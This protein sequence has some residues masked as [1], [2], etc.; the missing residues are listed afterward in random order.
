MD[1]KPNAWCRLLAVLPMVVLLFFTSVAG[2]QESVAGQDEKNSKDIHNLRPK[3]PT[4]ELVKQSE[5]AIERGLQFL[6]KT[7]NKDGS[8]GSHDPDIPDLAD[9]GFNLKNRG[10]QDGVRA[11]C[12]SI[13]AEAFL[14]QEKLTQPQQ[15]AFEKAVADLL[16]VKKFTPHLRAGSGENF[17]TWG[18]GYKLGFLV[19]L[20]EDPKGEKFDRQKIIESAESCVDG[21]TKFQTNDGGWHYYSTQML[22]SGSMSFNTSYISMCLQKA[23][24]LG[25]KVPEGVVEDSA[26]IVKRQRVPD[27]S[28]LYDSRF[29]LQGRPQLET[30]GSGAR[31]ISNSY[32]LYKMGYFSRKDLVVAMKIFDV[33]ENYLE[34]GR[35]RLIPHR[36]APHQISGYFFFFGYNYATE[37][38]TILGDQISQKRWDRFGWT[39]L[40]TQEKDGRWWDTAAGQYGD[41][42]GTGFALRCLQ[43]FVNET[44]RRSE[45]QPKKDFKEEN[46]DD[47]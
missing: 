45:Q 21:L 39:M 18:Y 2:A 34:A 24:T 29:I 30:L 36:D 5:E 37:V 13:C 20:L 43:R 12:T 4:E 32:A 7:Q 44:K 15:E 35:K 47:K 26:S 16:I 46:E 28:F 14:H 42:W 10:S 38:A 40:R 23:K 17:N 1:R 25:V 22:G 6:V 11:A 3:F 33:G 31:T 9:F 19:Q 41:K 8:W 27:G